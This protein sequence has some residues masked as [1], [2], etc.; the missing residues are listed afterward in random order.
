MTD[1]AVQIITS[2]AISTLLAAGVVWLTKSWISERLKN[3][4]KNEYDEKLATH[5]SQLQAQSDIEIERLRSQLSIAMVEHQ[6]KFS[7]FHTKRAEVIAEL[8]R[9]LVQAYFDTSSFVSNGGCTGKP[10]KEKYVTA[11]SSITDSYRCF[12][13]NRIYLQ[14]A[15][16]AKLEAFIQAM[17]DKATGFGVYVRYDD[18]NLPLATDEKKFKALI[19]ALEYFE[20]ELPA[21]KV[22]LEH[23]LRKI[24]S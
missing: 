2:G 14:E 6:I 5:K 7:G 13:K 24:L 17:R 8:Y 11:M 10:D 3:A 18:D 20:K 12:E 23:E 15:V 4:I 22:S 21:A 19:S 9:L 1:F 16:C